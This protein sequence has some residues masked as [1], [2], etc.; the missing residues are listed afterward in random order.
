MSK[1]QTGTLLHYL[2]ELVAPGGSPDLT[3]RQ[4]LERFASGDQAAFT[5]LVK[6]HGRLVWDVCRRT[7]GDEHDAEDAFQ[8]V[9]VVLACKAGSIRR[10]ESLSSWLHGVALRTAMNAK[11]KTTR[12]KAHE[13]RH[14]QSQSPATDSGID[15]QQVQTLL[16][17]EIERL[18][19]A[20]R[21]VFVLCCMEGTSVADAARELGKTKGATA[22]VL[23]R[24]RKRLQ[25]RLLERGVSL[26]SVLSAVALTG[27]QATAAIPVGLVSSTIRAGT[28]VAA[29]QVAT[30]GVVSESVA[31]LVKAMIKE[32]PHMSVTKL[33]IVLATVIVTG[34]L[35]GGA[36]WF[37]VSAH[38]EK[39]PADGP[40]ATANATRAG[41]RAPVAPRPLQL[42]GHP[43]GAPFANY[44]DSG[45]SLITVDWRGVVRLW[46][47]GTGR[48]LRSFKAIDCSVA[49]LARDGKA[50]AVGGWKEL[51][52]YDLSSGSILW[53]A[54]WPNRNG[55]RCWGVAFTPD[56][57]RVVAGSDD[58]FL[59][60]WDAASGKKQAEDYLGEEGGGSRAIVALVLSPDGR[61]LA[62]GARRYSLPADL[63]EKVRRGERV[64]ITNGLVGSN[65]L[66]LRSLDEGEEVEL[67]S[68]EVG[69]I[70]CHGVRP[71]AYSPDGRYVA[72]AFRTS[73][74]EAKGL[75][76]TAIRV[77]DVAKRR[78][79]PPFGA[80]QK[81]LTALTFSPDSASLASG[82]IDGTVCLWEVRTGKRRLHLKTTAATTGGTLLFSP[83]GRRLFSGMAIPEIWDV[84]I[85]VAADRSEA[86]RYTVEMLRALWTD[87]AA[88]DAE[89]AYRATCE[90][91]LAPGKAM[92][93]L[94][95]EI[96]SSTVAIIPRVA[97]LILDL[98]SENYD[99]R[100]SATKQLQQLGEMAMPA[101]RKA[102]IGRSSL[103]AKR[104]LEAVLAK[105]GG[106]IRVREASQIARAVE[107]MEHATSPAAREVLQSL[108]KDLPDSWAAIEAKAVL[109]RQISHLGNR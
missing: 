26:G 48:L 97:K 16:D 31:A 86:R 103:E 96:R 54:S 64:T 30:S 90:L 13:K 28:S 7:L 12:R 8:A 2:R 35:G 77:W 85:P 40:P 92:A 63:L 23:S 99:T 61:T 84:R 70:W 60:V 44:V 93:F 9:F 83:D 20:Y 34:A 73:P 21:A 14:T 46:D 42:D 72:A 15:W 104:R 76:T 91:E 109:G 38:T 98:D 29:Q 56:G 94:G 33:S 100:E 74:T 62:Y 95:E 37:S 27:T 108:V 5:S 80:S 79:L 58:C 41:S 18:P 68:R 51:A 105:D 71:V 47:A 57:K 22:V 78:E 107:A 106:P 67:G 50:L 89:H 11:R 101:L 52:V 36:G 75:D 82:C 55:G 87:L 24:A 81:G 66:R 4:L 53:K 1:A 43:A 25:E 17:E 45:K 59:R 88:D 3:D 39:Q 32:M 6:R 69:K 10:A 19:P 49:A 102:L 65:T